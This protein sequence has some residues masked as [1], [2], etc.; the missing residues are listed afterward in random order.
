VRGHP[1]RS[2]A[3]FLLPTPSVCLLHVIGRLG[4]RHRGTRASDCLDWADG[5]FGSALRRTCTKPGC[6]RARLRGSE[7]RSAP[8]CTLR[9]TGRMAGCDGLAGEARVQAG[10]RVR[11][12]P[13][14]PTLVR[15]PR[16][17]EWGAGRNT[18]Y[19][20]DQSNARS[21]ACHDACL[22]PPAYSPRS[23]FRVMSWNCRHASSTSRLLDY[24]LELDPHVALRSE[25]AH[26]WVLAPQ[27][28]GPGPTQPAGR[29]SG[30]STGG[31]PRHGQ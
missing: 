10:C 16:L 6:G 31:A 29:S 23:T 22:R 25:L 7:A 18:R 12:Q 28:L 5:G 30:W 1:P 13:H 15:Q 19:D 11:A 21:A 20:L 26:P 3:N 27:T 4:R 14:Q 17:G 9:R 24:L 8:T 2:S